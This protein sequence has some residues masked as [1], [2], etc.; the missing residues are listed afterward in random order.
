M[1][2]AFDEAQEKH[3]KEQIS[4]LK[5][6]ISDLKDK[7]KIS[8]ED[9]ASSLGK[10]ST[11]KELHARKQEDYRRLHLQYLELK[12]KHERASHRLDFF[13][14]ESS[15]DIEDL[16]RA[17]A[18]VKSK[19]DKEALK[20]QFEFLLPLDDTSISN[21]A[22]LRAL[23]AVN[24]DT[25]LE[26]D[27]A[28]K[29]LD[30]EH[31]LTRE[32]KAKLTNSEEKNLQMKREYELQLEDLNKTIDEKHRR[33]IQLQKQFE[34][35]VYGTHQIKITD[36]SVVDPRTGF[37]S[38]SA[39]AEP[40]QGNLAR[41]E[42]LMQ[43]HL[44]RLDITEDGRG[45]FKTTA[46][47]LFV[48]LDFF[49]FETNCTKVHTGLRI[50]LNHTCNYKVQVN[51]TFLRYLLKGYM[52]IE[53]H[54]AIGSTFHTVGLSHTR[55]AHLLDDE[56][57]AAGR[58]FPM[59]VQIFSSSDPS[60]ILAVLHFWVRFQVPMDRAFRLYRER[61]KALKSIQ[62]EQVDSDD[63]SQIK[64]MN[65]LTVHVQSI[66]TQLFKRQATGMTAPSLFV[67]YQFF[68]EP[69]HATK[70]V[71]NSLQPVFD[72]R[73]VFLVPETDELDRYLE[74]T[75]L[76]FLVVDEDDPEIDNYFG[77][78]TLQ[79]QDLRAGTTAAQNLSLLDASGDIVGTLH[80]SWEWQRPYRLRGLQAEDKDMLTPRVEVAAQSE[81]DSSQQLEEPKSSSVQIFVSPPTPQ[82]YTAEETSSTVPSNPQEHRALSK[83]A[84]EHPS[85]E[86]IE[87][88]P[89]SES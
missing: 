7:V 9:Y 36:D 32:F 73:Q 39:A 80:V 84:A 8:Q 72:S 68:Q 19:D 30:L 74:N 83:A 51:E 75:D 22:E 87:P 31:A 24:A 50:P 27:K 62:G 18:I 48:T 21:Q 3:F 61:L 47:S 40:F 66:D 71:K 53:V 43:M 14:N 28:R 6:E 56:T 38:A 89:E 44:L 59:A 82:K 15:T 58:K 2:A 1:K 17:L 16:D 5:A 76:R 10:L 54:Q 88:F 37:M 12:E 35:I 57:V 33:I 20:Q 45:F 11:E 67:S 78:A 69:E 4:Q 77:I 70:T 64:E 46:P 49:D 23:K 52:L 79:L 13:L 41:G 25:A 60:A 55:F 34:N 85:L 42:N 29:M 65:G 81:F 26:L 63:L 86:A